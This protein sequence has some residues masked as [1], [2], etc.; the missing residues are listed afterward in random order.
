MATLTRTPHKTLPIV[1]LLIVVLVTIFLFSKR[2]LDPH[3]SLYAAIDRYNPLPDPEIDHSK[4]KTGIGYVDSEPIEKTPFL[5]TNSNDLEFVNDDSIS[6]NETGFIDSESTD[7]NPLPQSKP[8][9]LESINDDSVSESE[10]GIADS[11]N[12]E[13]TQVHEE[14]E[15]VAES[16]KKSVDWG[17]SCNMHSG[18]W[19]RDEEYPIY[20]PGSCPFVDEAFDCQANARYDKKYMKCLWEPD[21]CELPT[22][23]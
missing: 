12:V 19:V 9:D 5:Q 7:E 2:T 20:K 16:V 10:T 6:K 22:S 13:I 8:N 15:A 17:K 3:L 11:E 4:S 18:K 1:F 14:D 21:S 23:V